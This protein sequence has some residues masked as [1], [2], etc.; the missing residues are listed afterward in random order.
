M[1]TRREFL[2]ILGL[3]VIGASTGVYMKRAKSQNNISPNVILILIDDQGWGATSM[4]SDRKIPD[5]ASDFIATPNLKKLAERGVRF[6]HGYAPHPNCSP[7]RYSILTG[8]SPAKLGMTDIIGRNQGKYYVGNK[9]I[10]P[11]HVNAISDE[12]VTLPEWIKKFR[13][14]YVTAHFGKW[15]LAGGGPE[16]HGF[17]SSDGATGNRQGNAKIQDNPKRIFGVTDR[18]NQWMERQVKSQRPFFLQI[19]H[20]ATH[21][22]I[23]ALEFTRKKVAARNPGKRHT[24]V[25]HAAMT[26]D[27]DIGVGQTLTKVKELGIEDSTYVIYLADNGTYPLPNPGNTNGPIHGW[28]ATIWEGGIRVPFVIAGPNIRP[29]QCDERVVGYDLFPTICSWLNIKNTPNGIEGGSLVPLLLDQKYNRVKRLHD[30]LVFHWPHY[31][32]NKA[33]QPATAIYSGDYKLLKLWESGRVLLFDLEKD[34]AETNDLSEQLPD[35]TTDMENKLISYLREIH[36]GM[37]VKNLDYNAKI[38][39]G[40]EY[41]LIK[42]KLIKEPYFIIK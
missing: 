11:K 16:K 39:P 17:D 5:S 33:S 24:H 9:L 30:F 35:L 19:S 4:I 12:E 34:L 38:D 18:A 10:P 2:T 36:A 13:P 42:E 14:E 8:K 40:K 3:G 6:S 32:L 22:G 25:D 28:K 27:L 37:P 15:H 23:E 26:E 20:Y 31:Q 7:S 21:L 29:G 1:S 41:A